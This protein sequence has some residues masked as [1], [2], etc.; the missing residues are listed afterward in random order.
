MMVELARLLLAWRP[1]FPRYITWMRVI[2]TLLGLLLATGKRTVTS[3]L[4]VRG[5]QHRPWAPDYL[6]FSRAPW[7]SDALFKQ[8][9]AASIQTAERFTPESPLIFAVDDTYLPKSGKKIRAARWLRDPLSPPFQVNLRWGIRYFHIAHILPLFQL[10]QDPR[11]VSIDFTPAPS[12]KRPGKKASPEELS[13]F[14]E[15][16][17]N[18]N[19]SLLAVQ[20]FKLLRSNL[21]SLGLKSRAVLILGDSS[22]TN[23]NV[24]KNLPDRL[25]YL[26]RTRADLRLCEPAN[27]GGRKVY[28]API[29]TP[30]AIRQD[31]E[32]PWSEASLFY[33]GSF[34]TVRFKERNNILW[35]TGAG[36]TP[37]RLIIIAP[38][39]YHPHGHSK[40]RCYRDPAYLITTDTESCASTLIQAYLAR[41]Q[42]E[43]E[44]RDLK[45]GLGVGQAQVY[46]DK[47]VSRLHST[48]VALWSTVKLAA[49]RTYGL[50]RTQAYPTRPNWY[51]QKPG[52]RPSQ[53]DIIEALRKSLQ[54]EGPLDFLLQAITPKP[55]NKGLIAVNPVPEQAKM[56]A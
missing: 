39:P 56:V 14:K 28:G 49:W 43:V 16:K 42:I 12:V 37:V 45:T 18:T 19:L 41:W 3:S 13:Q 33:A 48:H 54:N 36:R 31:P 22:Y 35:Q 2:S 1:V 50:E 55:R 27:K 15:A 46:N 51:P 9:L 10:G 23:S 20:R 30:L 17:K 53:P 7:E 52:E 4:A 44:H 21:D 40:K 6:V 34:R 47:S 24:L 25:S 29:P 32:H 38:T 11:A 8:V 5:L 26:G